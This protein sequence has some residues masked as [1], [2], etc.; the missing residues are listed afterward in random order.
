MLGGWKAGKPGCLSCH[1]LE[2]RHLTSDLRSILSF[3]PCFS[4]HNS[5]LDVGR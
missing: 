3:R 5:T 2:G 4:I 1:P